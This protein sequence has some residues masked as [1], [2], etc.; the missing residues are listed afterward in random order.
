MR[1]K[2]MT[3]E[4]QTTRKRKTEMDKKTKHKIVKWNLKF[5][6]EH[7]LEENG[8]VWIDDKDVREQME[9]ELNLSPL[10]E[11]EIYD[12]HIEE[13]KHNYKGWLEDVIYRYLKR[14]NNDEQI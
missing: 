5:H 13:Y 7:L 12:I 4:Q 14:V 1:K 8:W 2:Q 6:L 10:T 9:E 3:K 11:D